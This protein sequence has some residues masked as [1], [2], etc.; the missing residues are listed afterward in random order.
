MFAFKNSGISCLA[1]IFQVQ[2][3]QSEHNNPVWQCMQ[4]CMAVYTTPASHVPIFFRRLIRTYGFVVKVTCRV[5][6]DLGSIPA[7]C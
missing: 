6:G 7:G 4:S 2:L 3:E 5:S 1:L